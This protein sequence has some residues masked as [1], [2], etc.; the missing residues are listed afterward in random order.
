M[1]LLH[2]T[3]QLSPRKSPRKSPLKPKPKQSSIFSLFLSPRKSP[4]K[5]KPKQSSIFSLFL[6]PF[7]TKITLLSPRKLPHKSMSLSLL[8][9]PRK[10]A[11]L[12]RISMSLMHFIS[13]KSLFKSLKYFELDA[14]RNAALLVN[15]TLSSSVRLKISNLKQ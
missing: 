15:L 9:K 2:L 6:S 13:L 14:A 12:T 8:H 3:S 1:A 4:R 7:K 5:P 10:P 11:N